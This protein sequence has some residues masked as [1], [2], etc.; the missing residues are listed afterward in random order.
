MTSADTA[1]NILKRWNMK[2]GW[3]SS[4]CIRWSRRMHKRHPRASWGADQSL[5]SESSRVLTH[6]P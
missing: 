1:A 4:W 6:S 2:A 5:A 3:I